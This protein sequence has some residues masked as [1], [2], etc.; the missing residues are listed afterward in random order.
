MEVAMSNIKRLFLLLAALLVIGA[1]IIII[2]RPGKSLAS[3]DS[4]YI[5]IENTLRL[6]LEI[7]A[8]ARYTLDDSRLSEVLANDPRG[9]YMAEDGADK[10][11]LMAVQ[12]YTGNSNI[13]E[14]EIGMLD[15]WHAYYAYNRT[16]KQIY[17]NLVAMDMLPTPTPKPT[18][19]PNDVYVLRTTE[20]TP[21]SIYAGKTSPE[22]IPE[23]QELMRETGF[24][25]A[26][27]PP[28]RPETI[29]PV[30]FVI[31]SITVDNDLAHVVGDYTYAKVD[32]TFAK[33]DG[34]WYL[35]GQSIIQWHG[36]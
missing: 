24:Q 6:Y 2:N 5:A 7:D 29:V 16:V 22:S 3:D 18:E 15:F 9:S 36:G 31:Q 23:I 11:F 1:M 34:Q 35:I 32:L 28:P 26:S 13:K 8:E 33:I 20:S 12:W 19:D 25:Y 4:D 14:G 30:S 10:Y 27:L 21:S 17:D